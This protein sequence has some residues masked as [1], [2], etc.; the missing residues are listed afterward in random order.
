MRRAAWVGVVAAGLLVALVTPSF[1]DLS[2]IDANDFSW[3]PDIGRVASDRFIGDWEGIQTPLVRVTINFRDRIPW[4]KI[5][6]ME[7]RFD[8]KGTNRPDYSATWFTHP[9]N[10]VGI[11]RFNCWLQK[12][13]GILGGELVL[14]SSETRYG[15]TLR[16]VTCAFPVGAMTRT[17][18]IRWY[19]Y[20]LRTDGT[21]TNLRYDRAPNQGAYPHL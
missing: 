4:G 21:V 19:V 5:W 15:R 16:S 8:T 1:G 7:V 14:D 18:T 13:F 6:L 20:V 10:D 2:R 3:R 11:R 17:K 12:G 9:D